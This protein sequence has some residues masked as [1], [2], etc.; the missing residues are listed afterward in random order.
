[1]FNSGA[2]LQPYCAYAIYCRICIIIF[3]IINF[4]SISYRQ[5][6]FFSQ[7]IARSSDEEE[8]GLLSPPH[9]LSLIP[10]AVFGH[11][12]YFG[13]DRSS[14]VYTYNFTLSVQLLC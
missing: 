8:A 11:Y 4:Q 5:V 10:Y 1:M 6:A 14:D 2:R 13:I 7:Q 9:N 3:F 12:N